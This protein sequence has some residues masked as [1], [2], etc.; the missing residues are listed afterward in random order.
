M[1]SKDLSSL[2]ARGRREVF[3]PE[4]VLPENLARW[5]PDFEFGEQHCAGETFTLLANALDEED[6]ESVRRR[7]SSHI[8]TNVEAAAVAADS[9]EV[10]WNQVRR[11]LK[12]NCPDVFVKESNT[13]L[14]L[15][16]D[17]SPDAITLRELVEAYFATERIEDF[18][19]DTCAVRGPCAS[20]KVVTRWPSVLFLHLKRFRRDDWGV[21]SKIEDHVLFEEELVSETLG[22]VYDLRAIAVHEGP[23]EGGHYVSYVR[24]SAGQWM[25]VD[26]ANQPVPTTFDAVRQVEAYLFI[27]RLREVTDTSGEGNKRA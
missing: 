19:C 6:L 26:D 27:F 8:W 9:F 3:Q 22:C 12:P 2:C 17:F 20:S 5:A 16:L 18:F 7:A 10:R 24:D 1:L 25:Y 21:V 14:G 15:H 13:N 23:Y 4:T 11:C